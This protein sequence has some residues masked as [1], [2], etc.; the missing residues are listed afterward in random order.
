MLKAKGVQV[1][2]A[3]DPD[4]N[5][6]IL[7]RRNRL[8]W[9]D[10]LNLV[11]GPGGVRVSVLSISMIC[12]SAYV[13]VACIPVVQCMRRRRLVRACVVA[14]E[15]EDGHRESARGVVEISR[16]LD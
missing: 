12:L 1:R 2:L 13:E 6:W 4:E 8:H 16:R 11:D 15:G 3:H 5:Q 7:K 9:F 10:E 14:L